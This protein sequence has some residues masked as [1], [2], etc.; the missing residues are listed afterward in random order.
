MVQIQSIKKG[1]GVHTQAL[2]LLKCIAEQTQSMDAEEEDH[3]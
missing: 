2:Q 1:E 3:W